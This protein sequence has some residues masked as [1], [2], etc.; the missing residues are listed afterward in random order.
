MSSFIPITRRGNYLV[1]DIFFLKG[2]TSEGEKIWLPPTANKATDNTNPEILRSL[3]NKTYWFFR[4]LLTIPANLK[5]G[6]QG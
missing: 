6:R 2:K 1:Q 4:L 5:C 3:T